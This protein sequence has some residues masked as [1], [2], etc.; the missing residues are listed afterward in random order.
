M[1]KTKLIFLST[2]M[3]ILILE[4]TPTYAEQLVRV[5]YSGTAS[6]RISIKPSTAPAYGKN[7][8]SMSGSSTSRA[9]PPWPKRWSERSGNRHSDVPAMLNA[10]SAGAL[11]G[12][13]ISVYINRFPFAFVVRNESKRPMT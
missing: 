6:Q 10:V 2:M 5:G 3:T 4:S 9:A 11:D 8:G 7:V 13:L 1:Q 12:K